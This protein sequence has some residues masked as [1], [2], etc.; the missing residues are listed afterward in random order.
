MHEVHQGVFG[1]K[2]EVN[3]ASCEVV[4]VWSWES[5]LARKRDGPA[6]TSTRYTLSLS[7]VTLSH[8][9]NQQSYQV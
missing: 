8:H 7:I 5:E 4:E 3:K 1:D 2:S 9:H 6:Q